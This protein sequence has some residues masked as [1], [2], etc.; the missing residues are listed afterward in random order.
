MY[1]N[2][3]I[4]LI[5]YLLCLILLDS[6]YNEIF[7]MNPELPILFSALFEAYH[8]DSLDE[9]MNQLSSVILEMVEIQ[10]DKDKSKLAN[11]YHQLLYL[12]SFLP[13]DSLAVRIFKRRLTIGSVFLLFNNF[14]ENK[15]PISNNLDDLVNEL[16]INCQEIFSK[17]SYSMYNL[18]EFLNI[19][20]DD[21]ISNIEQNKKNIILVEKMKLIVSEAN[22]ATREAM[23]LQGRAQVRF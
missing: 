17:S 23:E 10:I 4:N 22:R 12:I 16:K 2:E 15:I 9:N 1:S 20:L 19:I 7:G 14:K 6:N 11:I 21:L 18:I 3:E 5:F 8:S 13:N